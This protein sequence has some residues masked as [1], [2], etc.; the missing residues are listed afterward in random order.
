MLTRA[1]RRTNNHGLPSSIHDISDAVQRLLAGEVVA[2]PTETVYGLGADAL[3]ARAVQRVFDLKRRPGFNPLIVHVSGPEMAARVVAPGAWSADAAALARAFWPGPLTLVLPKGA[4]IPD[5]VTGGGPT[6]AVRCPDHPTALAL[7]YHLEHPLVGPSANLSG[8][9]SPTTAAH[10]RAAFP[11]DDVKVLDGGACAVGIESTVV[12]LTGPRPRILRPGAISAGDI[13]AVLGR[14]V[15]DPAGH[16]DTH[17]PD[18]RPR[19]DRPHRSP[20]QLDRHYAPHCMAVMY[21]TEFELLDFI[22]QSAIAGRGAIV[23]GLWETRQSLPPPHRFVQMPGDPVRYAAEMY[24]RIREADAQ[25]PAAIMIERPRANP[26]AVPD[27]PL[28]AAI[29]DRLSR[30]TTRP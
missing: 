15:E 1:I 29:I 16:S 5:A 28:W 25:F 4:S 10:V 19:G 2:F 17:S 24:A 14:V 23:L 22:G 13:A 26:P 7:L 18:D 30:A 12:D 6:V 8:S 9:V 3:N 27:D 11:P 21:T 20:G